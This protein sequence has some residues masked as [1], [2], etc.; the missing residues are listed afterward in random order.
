MSTY[1]HPRFS[2]ETDRAPRV[3]GELEDLAVAAEDA[4]SPAVRARLHEDMVVLAI[5]LADAIARRYV[6]RGI[7]TDDLVQVART[8]L[9]KAVRRYR[10]SK[11]CAFAAFATPTISGELKRWF[12]DHGWSVRPPRRVQ[13]LRQLAAVEEERLQRTLCRPPT[14]EELATALGVARSELDEVR[15]CSMGYRAVSLDGPDSSGHL[16]DRVLVTGSPMDAWDTSDALGR[17]IAVLSDRQRLILQLRFGEDCTQ[18]QIA[19]R[20]GVSQMQVSRLLRAM[21][22][23][24]R[25]ELDGVVTSGH[26]LAG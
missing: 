1:T 5:P 19:E 21:L 25:K 10:P 18:S 22:V 14:D 24:L 4:T 9:V 11:G 7:E 2:A 12:R 13:E 26:G 17:A 23:Q 8:G 6:G 20:I 15:L 16:A 3:D